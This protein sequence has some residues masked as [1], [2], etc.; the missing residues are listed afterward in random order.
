MTAADFWTILIALLC[1]VSCALIG[2]YLVLRRLSLLGDA[3]SHGV[4]P[5]IVIAFL[6]TGQRSPFVVMAGAMACGLLTAFLTQTL[7]TFG[8]VPEDASMGAVFTGLFALGVL[9]LSKFA[10]QVD[11]DPKCVFEG[12][13][14]LV[15]YR[16]ADVLPKLIV[17]LGLTIGFILIFWKELKI[18][19]FDPGLAKTMGISPLLMHYLLMALV[20]GVTVASFEA[21]GSILIIAMLIVPGACGHLLSDRL[22]GMMLWAAGVAASTSVVGY[23]LASWLNTNIAGMMAVTVGLHFVLAVLFAPRH[24]LVAKALR[25]LRLSLQIISEDVLATLYRGEEKHAP[26]LAFAGGPGGWRTS[27]A[28]R[29]LSRK[30][31]IMRLDDGNWSLTESG[32]DRARSLVRAHRLWEAFLEQNLNLPPDHLHAPAERMEHFIGPELQQ[33]LAAE[34]KQPGVDPHGKAIPPA[35]P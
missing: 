8:N 1:N 25:N 12:L 6:L 30:R 7:T 18:S 16:L 22:T 4:L 17:A 2:G 31:Q 23:A 26:G 10:R 15:P 20:A 9:L 32:R 24:G 35:Q 21:V 29:A 11:L 28:L 19:A 33:Q 27:L 13:L 34:L 3:I 5:G 14:E